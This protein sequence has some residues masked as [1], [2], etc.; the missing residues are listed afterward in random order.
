MKRVFLCL[1]VLVLLVGGLFTTRVFAT[2][3]TFEDGLTSTTRPAG[4]R[5][6]NYYS[7]LGMTTP[8]LRFHDS[9]Y[10]GAFPFNFVDGWGAVIDYGALDTL[11]GFIEFTTPANYVEIDALGQAAFDLNGAEP[12]FWSITAFD[13]NNN[14]VA[15]ASEMFGLDFVGSPNSPGDNPVPLGSL[16]LRVEASAISRVEINRDRKLG[17]DT[18]RFAPIPEP[19]TILLMSAGLLGFA[20]FRKKFKK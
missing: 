13:E 1:A 19:S 15:F 10:A 5:I 4:L 8:N 16:S 12:Y 17:I 18:I 3:I 2:T 20:A 9:T 11:T 14:Q 7:D 6:G